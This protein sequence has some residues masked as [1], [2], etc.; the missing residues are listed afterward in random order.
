MEPVVSE[1]SSEKCPREGCTYSL[2]HES[3]LVE[4][5]H[6][7]FESWKCPEHGVV[8]QETRKL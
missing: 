7:V 5:Q 4:M 3:S 1:L 8:R 2:V 6:S